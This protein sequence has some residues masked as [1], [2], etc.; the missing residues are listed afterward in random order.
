[1]QTTG[2]QMALEYDLRADVRPSARF[3]DLSTLVSVCCELIGWQ[4]P[5]PPDD[6]LAGYERQRLDGGLVD[7]TRESIL[8]GLDPLGAAYCSIKSPKERRGAGQTFT[9][10][11]AIGGMYG[12]VEQRYSDIERIVDPGAGSGRYVFAGL[13]RYPGATAVAIESDPVLA[14]VMRA[15]AHVLGLQD[16]LAILVQD[17]RETTLELIDRR[18]LFIGNPPYVRHHEIEPAWKTWYSDRLRSLGRPSSQLAGLHLHFFLKTLEL[19]KPGDVG[20]FITAAEWLD[21]NYG[22]SLRALM[23]NELGGRA[24]FVASPDL[25]VFNDAFVSACIACFEVGSASDTLEFAAIGSADRLSELP[26]GR[27]VRKSSAAIAKSWSHLV[28]ADVSEARYGTIEL[29]DLFRVSRGQVTGKN[30]VWVTESNPFGLP[31]RFLTP[32]ITGADEIVRATDHRID[33][34]GS[35]RRVV[36]LPPSLDELS[37]DE[38]AAIE[39]FLD[40]AQ[41]EGAHAGYIAQHRTPWWRVNLPSPPPVVMTYMGRRPPVFAINCA[42]ARLINVAHG[43]YPKVPISADVLE[44]LVAWLNGNVSRSAG[45]VYAGGLTKFEPSEAM[46]IRVPSLDTFATE[47][48]PE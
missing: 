34:L 20:C 45:R 26:C 27:P 3:A 7:R 47:A 25:P 31:E 42:G 13:E 41:S 22:E 39:R 19:A 28:T 30:S 8:L 46:R 44:R 33:D 10:A 4:P 12:W 6:G 36:D 11:G 43:L 2:S 40:W 15:N 14:L 21:V 1:M 37:G 24:V 5:D 38:R 35:L 16:R 23:L 9:P 48:T 18:T 29:G 17:Y 32:C